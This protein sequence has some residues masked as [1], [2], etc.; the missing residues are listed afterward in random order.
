MEERT[1][2][3]GQNESKIEEVAC[4]LVLPRPA[5]SLQ[6]GTG[7]SRELEHTGPAEKERVA[8][9]PQREQLKSTP[10]PPLSKGKGT[11]PFCSKH[12]IVKW[13]RVE[14]NESRILARERRIRARAWK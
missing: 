6:N 2:W 9:V 5:K 13:E 8:S 12:Q 10:E 1:G 11:E 3:R 4:L 14:V 7:F